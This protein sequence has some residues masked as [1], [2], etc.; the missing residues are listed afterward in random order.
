MCL[1]L[2]FLLLCSFCTSFSFYWFFAALFST[3]ADFGLFLI[4]VGVVLCSIHLA[5]QCYFKGFCYH[6]FCCCC[7]FFHLSLTI[8][9]AHSI[10]LSL[11]LIRL[12]FIPFTF[13]SFSVLLLFA[14]YPSHVSSCNHC[15]FAVSFALRQHF[16][17]PH[18]IYKLKVALFSF[19]L[20]DLLNVQPTLTGIL[21]A[22]QLCG[23]I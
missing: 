23:F 5:L 12:N 11:D 16:A 14:L 7:V 2:F 9:C 1:H 8:V 3:A 22:N 19:C 15:P 18:K 4:V 20:N 17:W 10:P 13:Y 6:L 21:A